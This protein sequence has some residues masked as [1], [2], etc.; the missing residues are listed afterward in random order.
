MFEET[1][2]RPHYP[3]MIGTNNSQLIFC[4]PPKVG[5]TNFKYMFVN[6]STNSTLPNNLNVHAHALM[7]KYGLIDIWHLLPHWDQ[8]SEIKGDYVKI[9]ITRHPLRRLISCYKQKRLELKSMLSKMPIDKL[10]GYE[11]IHNRTKNGNDLTFPEFV[12]FIIDTYDWVS[13][14]IFARHW[15]PVTSLCRV[16]YV[17]YDFILHLEHMEDDLDLLQAQG[18]LNKQARLPTWHRPMELQYSAQNTSIIEEDTRLHM[19]QL[20]PIQIAKLLKIYKW[21]FKIFGYSPVDFLWI[22]KTC[23]VKLYSYILKITML[24]MML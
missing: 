7:E 21:D 12:Q 1:S 5:C 23:K 22:C 4:L 6:L 2:A 15:L 9:M 16:C 24:E 17:Q 18:Y 8:I 10:K 13:H 11:A 3:T 20:S 19:K 14:N